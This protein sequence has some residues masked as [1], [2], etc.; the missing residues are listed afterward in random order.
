MLPQW[1]RIDLKPFWALSYGESQS[2]GIPEIIARRQVSVKIRFYL[3]PY[4]TAKAFNEICQRSRN[5]L[6]VEKR[7][8][9]VTNVWIVLSVFVVL[10]VLTTGCIERPVEYKYTLPEE[11]KE[12]KPLPTYSDIQSAESDYKYK[13]SLVTEQT[14]R[15]DLYYA[16]KSGTS[17]TQKENKAW[18]DDLSLQTT[19]F[20]KRNLDAIRT[21]N[22]YV[23][24]LNTENR[25]YSNEYLSGIISY[26][27]YRAEYDFYSRE[28]DRVIKNNEIMKSDIKKADN[29]LKNKINQ[30]NSA[31][32]R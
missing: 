30:Y 25:R 16:S 20:I 4:A 23:G 31:F 7:M 12:S 2:K 28:Y 19:E 8:K 27:Q 9:K 18:L 29:N 26:D 1:D 13:L 3:K 5:L 32:V 6:V 17:M 21:G 22:A 15:L 24:H 11:I 10:T 14:Q